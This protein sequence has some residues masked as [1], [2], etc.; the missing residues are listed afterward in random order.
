MTADATLIVAATALSFLTATL[1]VPRARHAA[2]RYQLT[3]RP[4]RGKLHTQATPYLGG[5]AIILAVATSISLLPAWTTMGATILI[6]GVV[7][8]LVGLID[9]ARKLGPG[10]RVA[11]ETAAA[12]LVVVSGVSMHVFGGP[13]DGVLTVGWLVLVT[14]AFNLLDN[15]DGAA[16]AV[17]VC[18]SVMLLAAALIGGQS[19]VIGLAG[20]IG[21]ASL[22][23]LIYN[24]H[25]AK[26][27]MGDTGSLFLGFVLAAAV[28]MLRFPANRL[29]GGVATSLMILPALFDTALVVLSRIRAG[30]PVYVGG[31][32]HTSHR[33][34]RLGISPEWVVVILGSA[35]LAC[36]GLGL[37]VGRGA[38]PVG[39][40]LLAVLA[41]AIPLLTTLMRMPVYEDLS[42][43]VRPE[44]ETGSVNTKRRE[45]AANAS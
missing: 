27:F 34:L 35:S 20:V 40:A 15:I 28:L 13:L 36:G 7:V 38:V 9:D 18:T 43:R 1:L 25:P 11:T 45:L 41:F 16:A 3:D 37:A 44:D 24:W 17:A 5:L 30:R 31:T 32:D 22:G 19:L 39:A 26:I 12:S 33:L 29:A 8:G 6:G 21:G 42:G 23:F 2:C 4:A 10:V 14:N